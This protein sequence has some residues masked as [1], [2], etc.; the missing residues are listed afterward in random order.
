MACSM[1]H[2]KPIKLL[3]ILAL[4][5]LPCCKQK[6]PSDTYVVVNSGGLGQDGFADVISLSGGP[7][8]NDNAVM[9]ISSINETYGYFDVDYG[10]N[11]YY[12]TVNYNGSGTFVANV[13]G[14]STGWSTVISNGQIL[15]MTGTFG[16]FL[17]NL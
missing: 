14:S 8:F 16:S 6:E 15:L 1:T 7:Y 2:M 13:G 17:I 4:V 3:A 9:N 10:S 11:S 5:A 12:G